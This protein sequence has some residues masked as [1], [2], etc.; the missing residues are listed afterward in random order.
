[1]EE[2]KDCNCCHSKISQKFMSILQE[3]KPEY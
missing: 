3:D 2:V 1:M